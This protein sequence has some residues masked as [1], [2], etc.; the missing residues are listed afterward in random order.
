MIFR[1]FSNPLG[2]GADVYVDVSLLKVHVSF[3]EV[4]CETICRYREFSVKSLNLSCAAV[5]GPNITQLVLH[6][7]KSAVNKNKLPSYPFSERLIL[8]KRAAE[9]N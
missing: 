6:S 5:S 9:W 4:G 7:V 1:K 3:L 8:G 2:K